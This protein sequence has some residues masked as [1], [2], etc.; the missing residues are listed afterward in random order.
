M[1]LIL[2]ERFRSDGLG[3]RVYSRGGAGHWRGRVRDG[4]SSGV[5]GVGAPV[6]LRLGDDEDGE[7]NDEARLFA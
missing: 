5:E 4:D 2:A 1:D 7:L 3:S 6:L